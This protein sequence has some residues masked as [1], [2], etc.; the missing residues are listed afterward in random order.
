MY[1]ANEKCEYMSE[2][3]DVTGNR[4]GENRTMINGGRKEETLNG[5]TWTGRER[6]KSSLKA[7]N[8]ER[9]VDRYIRGRERKREIER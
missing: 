4:N 2:T 6:N 5:T 3:A 7:E 9:K 1:L 8:R